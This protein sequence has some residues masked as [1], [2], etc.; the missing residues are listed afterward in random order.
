MYSPRA[1][2]FKIGM[3]NS[4]PLIDKRRRALST[5]HPGLEV[6]AYFPFSVFTE[7][8]LHKKF[9]C[10]RVEGE[11]FEDSEEIHTFISEEFRDA[12]MTEVRSQEK[13][14]SELEAENSKLLEQRKT[15]RQTVGRLSLNRR[16]AE[17]MFRTAVNS[18]IEMTH[19][20]LLHRAAWYL[21][22]YE[23]RHY[24][25][26][27]DRK[28]TRALIQNTTQL[29][30]REA[31]ALF[32]LLFEGSYERGKGPFLAGEEDTKFELYAESLQEAC[33]QHLANAIKRTETGIGVFPKGATE[34]E[35][36]C[37]LVVNKKILYRPRKEHF[38][39]YTDIVPFLRAQAGFLKSE[40]SL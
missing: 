1:K 7:S 18:R 16:E 10:L 8:Y 6:Q 28:K 3:T 32:S 35:I 23:G 9:D 25:V 21:A 5:G 15:L 37:Y 19:H 4:Y 20:A 34:G 36:R 40:A 2:L 24:S 31:D 14:I 33:T 12:G 13:R 22:S 30:W 17:D 26:I 11:W 38:K 29:N 27:Y 39:M